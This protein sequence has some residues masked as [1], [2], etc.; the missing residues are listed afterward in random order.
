MVSRQTARLSL[1]RDR[2]LHAAI[3]M[4]DESGVEAMSLYNHVANKDDLL[5]GALDLV[6]AECEE[7]DP[8]GEWDVAVRRSAVT[9]NRALRQHPWA[10]TLLM[11]ASRIREARL[12]YMDALLGRLRSA[13]FT[14][15]TTFDVYHVLDGHIFG[16]SLWQISHSFTPAQIAAMRA[17]F[18]NAITADAYPHLREHGAQHLALDA[19]RDVDAFE[20]GLDL[21]L[22]GLRA[23]LGRS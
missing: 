20:L 21:I 12:H 2:I 16:F 17:V 8:E 15:E 10:C 9:V 13:G 4:A 1:S 6:L 5:D 19:R 18:D 7:P 23:R 11:G 14:A 3:E 22:D